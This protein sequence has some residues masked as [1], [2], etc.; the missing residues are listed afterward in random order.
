[1]TDTQGK[2]LVAPPNMPD[3]RFQKTVIYMWKHDISGAG[4]VI[5]N[6][7]CN[8]QTLLLKLLEDKKPNS[9]LIGFLIANDIKIDEVDENE[10]NVLFRVVKNNDLLNTELFLDEKILNINHKNSEGNTVLIYAALKGEEYLPMMTELLKYGANPNIADKKGSTLIEKL[11]DVILHHNNKKEISSSL[12]EC[13]N[14]NE[15]YML[16]LKNIFENS[17]VL[18]RKLN[19]AGKPLFFD[20]VFYGNNPLFDLL[21]SHGSDINQKDKEGK[22]L[23]T[24]WI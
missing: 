19:S 5:I 9:D 14:T 24:S 20:P 22:K 17:K 2:F 8:H 4:G 23:I 18:L 1:M 21:K 6:K 11:I 7:K 13:I 3:W 15:D 12:L 16:I 10:E